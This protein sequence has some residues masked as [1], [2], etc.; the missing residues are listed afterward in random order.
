MDVA[1]A[2]PSVARGCLLR[3]M[4]N[5]GLDE[6]LANW[7]DSFMRGRRVIISADGR[8]D[9]SMEDN[10]PAARL[11]SIS[12]VLLA[13][14]IAEIHEAVQ[15]QVGDSRGISFVDDVTWI[16]EGTGIDDVVRKPE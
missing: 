5:M 1:A 14:Y 6:R 3:K 10:G 11:P 4:R 8:D 13:I 7:K 2:F 16:L 12:S 15:S 9:E